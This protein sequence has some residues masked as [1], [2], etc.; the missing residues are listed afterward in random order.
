MDVY[1]ERMLQHQ[2]STLDITVQADAQIDT[3]SL[4][5]TTDTSGTIG[6]IQ[7]LQ[8]QAPLALH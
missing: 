5:G 2:Q 1:T 7:A 8:L 6:A 3:V 4:T